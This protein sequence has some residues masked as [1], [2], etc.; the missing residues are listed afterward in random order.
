MRRTPIAALLLALAGT[1]QAGP[2]ELTVVS[3][4]SMKD[5]LVGMF[6]NFEKETGHT[7]AVSW[8][9]PAQLKAKV[10]GSDHPD[11]V[12]APEE[13]MNALDRDGQTQSG[14][15]AAL[16]R[17]GLGVVVR[18]D[19]KGP[20]VST[21]ASFKQALLDAKSL[22][23]VD[24]Q[25]SADGVKARAVVERLGLADALKAK[26]QLGNGANAIAPVGFGNVELGLHPIH[27]VM[28][29]K[30]VRLLA[31]VPAELQQWTRYDLALIT[32][33][34]NPAEAE[35]L[36]TW[37]RAASAKARLSTLGIEAAP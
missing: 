36:M 7:V 17:V 29:T 28:A 15:R 33:A 3:V 20:D 6:A 21:A 2:G 23:Y 11:V 32:D 25:E 31:P 34:P 22:I 37:L 4:T 9:S 10:H 26:T 27:H 12:I 8:A 19:A 14:S 16:G 18:H 35:R 24:P 13:A 5:V 30:D 1:A